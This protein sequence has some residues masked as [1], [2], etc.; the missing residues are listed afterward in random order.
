MARLMR[1][2]RT[3]LVPGVGYARRGVVHEVPD[4]LVGE[5]VASGEW[6]HVTPPT[7]KP[8]VPAPGAHLAKAKPKR[9]R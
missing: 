6:E 4:E 2:A 3:R 5:L 9:G 1:T 8:V 7:S